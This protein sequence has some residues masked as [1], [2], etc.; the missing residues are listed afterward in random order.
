MAETPEQSELNL[1]DFLTTRA[2]GASD[3]RLA[4]DTG[5]GFLIAVIALVWRPNGWFPLASA[6]LCFAAFGGW[7]IADREL[8]ERNR[9][10]ANSTIPLR[11]LHLARIIAAA[12]GGA[13][14]VALLI[15]LL[16]LALGTWIS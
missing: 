5:F 12:L 11:L 2:R 3:L 9:E 15:G 16:G 7:G 8:R 10:S 4:L 1:R 6:A 13:A 14:A